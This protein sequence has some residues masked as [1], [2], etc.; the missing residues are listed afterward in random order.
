MDVLQMVGESLQS[1]NSG[2]TRKNVIKALEKGY[3]HN[4]I[5]KHMLEVMEVVGKKI[6]RKRIVCS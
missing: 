1:G 6:Q 4:E 2:E 3:S 5:L